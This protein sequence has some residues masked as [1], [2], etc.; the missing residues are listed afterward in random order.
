MAVAEHPA[1]CR[2]RRDGPV[3]TCDDVVVAST[4][5]GLWL[6]A[7]DGGEP[8]PPAKSIRHKGQG[9]L[10]MIANRC[11]HR[12]RK[13]SGRLMQSAV[14]PDLRLS[15]VDLHRKPWISC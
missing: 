5:G 9:K 6:S 14:L 2:R 3:A 12:L 11:Y 8:M 4:G 7:G 15:S 13:S 1:A 10:G